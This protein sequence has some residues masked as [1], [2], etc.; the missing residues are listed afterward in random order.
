LLGKR[1]AGRIEELLVAQ[2]RSHAQAQALPASLDA[3]D[4]VR[5]AVSGG[6]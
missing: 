2:A 1:A 6:A 5:D 4:R 3:P